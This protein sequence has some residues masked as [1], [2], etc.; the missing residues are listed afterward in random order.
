MASSTLA[1]ASTEPRRARRSGLWRELR[2]RPAFAVSGAFA[3]LVCAMAAAPQA[4]AGWFADG[5]P[6]GL[7][8][9]PLFQPVG[10]LAHSSRVSGVKPEFLGGVVL[11]AVKVG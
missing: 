1:S 4:F 3:L 9:S 5:D 6:D 10:G 2:R 8:L 11:A 7:P